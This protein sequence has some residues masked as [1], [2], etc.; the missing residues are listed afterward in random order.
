MDFGLTDEQRSIVEVTR[1]FVER[2]LYPHE[3]EV[4][5]TG[6]LRPELAAQIRSKALA[7]GLYA[8]NMPEEVGGAGLD[9][10]TWVL[11]EK[12]LGRASYALQYTGVV[13]PS[14]I[15]LAG[16]EAQRERYL[17]PCVRGEKIDC[18][19]MTEPGAG[20]DMRS[21]RTRAVRDGD[22]GWRIRGTK[23]FISHADEADFVIL[24]AVTGADDAGRPTMS[25]FLVDLDTP[26][27]TVH[28]G[29]RNVSH[30][31]YTN[32]IL[33]FDDVVVGDDAVLGEVDKGFELAGT[34]LGSTRLQVAASCLGRAERALELAVK[35]AATREQ[36]GQPIGR[37]QGVGFKLADMATE[38]RA[39]ELMTLHAA[40]KHDQGTATDADIAMA[41]LKATEMLAMVSDEAIQIH[42]GMGLMDE[43]PLER[44]WRDARIER[45]W[46][47]TSEIQRHI[48]SRSLL[49]PLGA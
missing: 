7:A 34:W 39:A 42:G 5:R 23:H 40:W 27:L 20:S 18:L 2:E 4:E 10:V 6:V 38:L 1:A 41:K 3:E 37:F 33:D 31:G 36:F 48:I 12:E 43:L 13:R 26:G 35:Q 29:Y 21:M 49:R 11:Y 45:I 44:I 24:V 28:P 9:T 47:G 16:T 30:R 8:A 17:Y 25:T 15:L 32:S 46:D 14:N 19:A 22:G